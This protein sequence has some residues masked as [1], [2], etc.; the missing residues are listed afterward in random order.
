[1]GNQSGIVAGMSITVELPP[2]LDQDVKRIPDVEKRVLSFLRNQVEHEKWRTAR[3]SEQAVRL[4][5]ES[6]ADA[7]QMKAEGV[8]RE[9]LFRRFFE[10]YDKVAEQQ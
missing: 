6:K 8:P 2:D 9:E 7:A 5:E 10:A 3:Y 4:L 1:M